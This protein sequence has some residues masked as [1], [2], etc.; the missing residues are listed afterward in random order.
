M[1]TDNPATNTQAL[2]DYVAKGHAIDGMNLATPGG[3]GLALLSVPDG[4]KVQ[5]MTGTAMFWS[6]RPDRPRGTARLLTT[7]AFI[8]WV[9]RQKTSNTAIFAK[10]TDAPSMT[11]VI[12]YTAGSYHTADLYEPEWGDYRAGYQPALSAE[13]KHWFGIDGTLQPQVTFAQFIED[14]SGDIAGP[15]GAV[16]H[17]NEYALMKRLRLICG[18]LGQ[19]LDASRNL[20]VNESSKVKSVISPTSGEILTVYESVHEGEAGAQISIPT[21]F[22]IDVPIFEGG[23]RYRIPVRLRY[24]KSESVVKFGCMIYRP[25]LY[26]RN[27]WDEIMLQ[28]STDTACP[29]FEGDAEPVWT[30]VK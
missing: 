27:A 19:M 20:I 12:N 26:V 8:D 1:T 10:A 3:P 30:P 2:I 25:D 23:V 24:R 7:K 4:R 21:A 14:N 13:W 17:P 9:N 15:P 16:E 28:V 5:D 29:I 18:D 6:A 22:V 11:A